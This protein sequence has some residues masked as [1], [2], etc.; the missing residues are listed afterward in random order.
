MEKTGTRSIEI[1]TDPNHPASF[2]HPEKVFD[3]LR[4]EKGFAKSKLEHVR[5]ALYT[6]CS[7]SQHKRL[8]NKFSRMM[9]RSDN[10]DHRWQMD[11]MKIEKFTT[12]QEKPFKYLLLII[13]VFTRYLYGVPLYEKSGKEVT[14]ATEL[15]FMT[16]G[17]IPYSI[18]S[19]AGLEFNNQSFKDLCKKYKIQH[20]LTVPKISHASIVERVILSLRIKIG[21]MMTH[22]NSLDIMDAIGYAINAYN[23]SL[24][25]SLGMSPHDA[26]FGS[27][28]NKQLANFTSLMRNNKTSQDRKERNVQR[29][30]FKVGEEVRLPKYRQYRGRLFKKAHEQTFGDDVYKI[31]E[32]FLSD[33]KKP[34]YRLKFPANPINGKVS[35]SVLRKQKSAYYSPEL[36]STGVNS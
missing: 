34:V 2:S 3:Y 30:N 31:E 36:S 20:Y 29:I 22:M 10:S 17:K 6:L 7:Y 16:T 25:S 32:V 1:Y 33:K 23:N 5:K 13:D 4:K 26:N 27:D 14:E 9:T 15:I 24:H 8:V 21:K 19:D 35:H 18:T 12:D 28:A 11:L